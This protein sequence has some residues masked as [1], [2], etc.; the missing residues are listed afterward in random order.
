MVSRYNEKSR[1][2]NITLFDGGDSGVLSVS[3]GED[4][5]C[6]LFIVEVQTVGEVS[7]KTPMKFGS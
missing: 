1:E 2:S 5:K 6:V 4:I 3:D 7:N